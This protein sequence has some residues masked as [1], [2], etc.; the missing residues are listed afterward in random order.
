M[1]RIIISAF[2]L[3]NI[4]SGINPPQ[5]GNFPDGFWEK[6]RQQGV[7]QN[8]GDPGWVNKISNQI[9]DP[10]RDTQLEF[11]IPV[12]LGKYA[13]VST[14]Y[15]NA[16][17]FDQ[18]L[19]GDN[20]MGSMKD[21]FN[22]ISYGN[23]EIDGASQGWY[24]SSLTMTQAVDNARQ[25][26]AEIAA[27]ADPDFDYA[28]YDNDGPDNVPNSGDDDGY[29]DGIIVVYSGCGAEWGEG[30]NNLW[31]HMSS[32]SS[33]QYETNDAGANG[34]NII[35][36]TY[37][38][39][40]ELAGG[41]DCYTDIIRPIGVYAHEFGHV[42]GLP[43]LY[44]RDAS[45]GNSEGL[46]EWCLMAS[47]SWMGWAGDTPAHMSSW[48]KIQMGWIE[49]TV[50]DNNTNNVQIAQ[51]VT[52]PST[53]KIWED[54]YNWSR[55]FLI[56][57]RQ[58]IGF[59]SEL[60]GPGLLV[61]H[62]NENRGY[63]PNAWSSGSVNDNEQN[64]LVDLEEAD[65]DNDLDNESNRGDNGD[66]F[67]GTSG[68]T[69]FDDNSNPATTRN[70][71]SET[72]ISLTNISNPDSIMTVDIETRPQYGYAVAYDEMGM[73]LYGFGNS[74]ESDKWSGVSFEA[75]E[76]GYLTE[77][78]FGVRY[79]MNWTVYVYDSFN[80]TAPGTLMESISGSS[81]R[82]NWVTVAVNSVPIDAGQD[83]F[84]AVKFESETYPISFDNTGALSGRSYYSTDGSYFDN[85]LSAYGDAN[86]RAKI[87]TDAF[88]S[89]EENINLPNKISLFPNYPNPFNP[90][91]TLSFSLINNYHVL[92]EVYDIKGRNIETLVN[93]KLSIGRHNI[94]WDGSQYSSGI[95]FIK[96]RTE[97]IEMNQKIMLLK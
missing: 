31:P 3:I 28:Q 46:G 72:G 34:S 68:N 48:C 12:L 61:Y 2:L 50:V 36:S 5:N 24:Q 93:S 32:L 20:P 95:Y 35:V 75:E 96:L 71:G 44:D 83:F 54:D 79:P 29:V 57:N 94:R 1:N 87:S 81:D 25:Y 6:M 43:D 8:Y 91:T 11:F 26:V 17:D 14:T 77:I 60:H 76:S 30:N 18:L 19:F 92:L 16:T 47:G 70:D 49:P 89:I 33:Y 53:L 38:V 65:G 84:V 9:N 42:L 73:S 80:G 67:P 15:F 39:C 21:Y 37:A 55:Y 23:F 62:V 41:G 59:D 66:P 52:S 86:I 13:D 22:E 10:S 64:K 90:T 4:V 69:T 97:N 27:L 45:D 40:P 78:D 82:N 85:I 88:I 58:A 63:G 51:L 74:E 56:E 7:G